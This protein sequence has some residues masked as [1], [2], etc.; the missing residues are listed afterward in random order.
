[1]SQILS[2]ILH[3]VF[4]L[5]FVYAGVLK[6]RE[7]MVFLDDVRSFNLLPDPYAAML[8]LF[9]PW[10]EIF[11]GLAAA[12]GVLGRGFLRPGGLLVLNLCLLVFLGALGLAWSRGT[13]IRCGC[14][15]GGEDAAANYVLLVS[16]DVL[17]LATGL[18]A[19]W[20]G[21]AKPALPA[22]AE[23]TA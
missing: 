20:L 6:A 5:V 1:M 4:G 9:L 8:A 13:D 7:P 3:L 15:G 12:S 21:R 23:A 2:R 10:L 11:A 18:L 22:P 14:F 17:L 16:R 19:A